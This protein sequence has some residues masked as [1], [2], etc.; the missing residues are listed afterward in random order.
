VHT[1]YP[2]SLQ[3]TWGIPTEWRAEELASPWHSS[4]SQAAEN[5]S[6]A[7]CWGICWWILVENR[8]NK[9]IEPRAIYTGITS[10]IGTTYNKQKQ[11]SCWCLGGCSY[12]PERWES[13]NMRAILCPETECM[14]QTLLRLQLSH[15]DNPCDSGIVIT[16]QLRNL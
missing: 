4:R 13:H 7:S 9:Q 3:R 5:R 15:L 2:Y 12:L 10:K 8:G 11:V 6:A 16:R 14:Q 1:L